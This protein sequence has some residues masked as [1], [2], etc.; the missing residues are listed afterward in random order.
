[1]TSHPCWLV[2]DGEQANLAAE[3]GIVAYDLHK[4]NDYRR[5]GGMIAQRDVHRLYQMYN[6]KFYQTSSLL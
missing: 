5:L 6:N 2:V 1:M 3:P 4:L